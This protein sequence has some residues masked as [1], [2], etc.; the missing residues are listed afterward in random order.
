MDDV[1]TISIFTDRVQ[2]KNTSNV[3]RADEWKVAV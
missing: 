1:N 2:F 3:L